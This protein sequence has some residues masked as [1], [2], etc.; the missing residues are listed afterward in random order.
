VLQSIKKRIVEFFATGT[1]LGKLPFMPGT[2]GTLWGIPIAWCWA[3]HS[4]VFYS[5]ASL[6]LFLF[7]VWISELH[8]RYTHAHD[9]GEIVIDEVI[10]YVIAAAFLPFSWISFLAAFL[11]FRF[12]D[13]V[14]PF[15]IRHLDRHVR[16]GFGTVI[17]DV[18]AGVFANLV[19]QVAFYFWGAQ[20]V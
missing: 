8:E 4:A 18:L 3:Q 9:P 5:L 12:F 6:L 20:L 15:P 7:A 16:G 10:G 1:Y 19:L 13:I 14:K 11:V 17:D 2:W